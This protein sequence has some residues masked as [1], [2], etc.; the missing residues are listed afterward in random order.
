MTLN[1][2]YLTGKNILIKAGIENPAFDA[3]CIF[4]FCF[5]LNRQDIILYRNKTADSKQEKAFLDLIQQRSNGRPLQY[6]LGEWSF[7]D[8]KFNVGEGVLIPRDDTEV[9]VNATLNLIKNIKNPKI[10]DLCSGSGAIALSLAYNR[11]DADIKAIELS[12]IALKY[13]NKN[14]ELNNIN[15]VVA[16]KSNVLTENVKNKFIDFDIIVS[17]PPYIPTDDIENL[18]KEVKNEPVMAL[19]G[20]NDGLDFYKVIAAKW[21][22]ALKKNGYMCFEIGIGQSI[23][24]V[25]ILKNKDAKEIEIIKDL[26]GINRVITA[27]F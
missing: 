17:N 26:N 11:P 18:Q 9:L 3:M 21:K 16:L 7:M 25:N 15:N 2:V 6:I 10:L 13:L 1:E 4:E 20:G 12:D 22:V 19:D 8:L 24:V 14:I 23:D 5:K 27:K